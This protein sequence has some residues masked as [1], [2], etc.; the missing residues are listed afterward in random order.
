M[1]N[2]KRSFDYIN[3]LHRINSC[4]KEKHLD[5]LRALIKVHGNENFKEA[6]LLAQALFKKRTEIVLAELKEVDEREGKFHMI[7]FGS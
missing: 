7:K 6:G 3:I 5:N 1:K 4:E 2:T